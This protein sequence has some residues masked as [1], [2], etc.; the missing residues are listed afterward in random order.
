MVGVYRGIVN[1]AL[2]FPHLAQAFY[3]KGPGRATRELKTL[4][5]AAM[6]R[7]EIKRIDTAV[8]ADHFVG[9]MRDNLHLQVVLGLREAPI[10]DALRRRAAGAVELFLRGIAITPQDR[11][12]SRL[13]VTRG[14]SAV[15]SCEDG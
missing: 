15:A 10:E 6:T 4:L 1:E 5:D 3:D 14:K 8:A 12:A 11:E 9:M 13:T 2:R 7:G